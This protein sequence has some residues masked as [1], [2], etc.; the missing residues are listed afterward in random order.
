MLVEIR[1]AKFLETV[2]TGKDI[3]VELVL[4]KRYMEMVRKFSYYA[5]KIHEE[6]SMRT[7]PSIPPQL[8]R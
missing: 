8:S 1:K 7:R 5:L 6:K 4:C 3:I 2:I